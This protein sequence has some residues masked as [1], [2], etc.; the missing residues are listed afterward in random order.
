MPQRP[1][2]PSTMNAVYLTGHGG[3]EV[4]EYVDTAPVPTPDAGEVLIEVTAC[5]MNNTDIWV[6]E[7]AYGTDDDPN[8]TASWRRG[9]SDNSLQFPRI[10]GG[11]TVGVIVDTG[12]SVDPAR[13][14]ERVMIDFSIYNGDGISLSDIDY[15]GPR[16]RWWLCRIY[17]CSF[18]SS[19]PQPHRHERR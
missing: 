3:P 18:R 1:D 2:I 17:G 5:G 6:R 9:S 16:T 11:D 4:L 19:P 14:G 7:G 10:Q 8:A 13:I 12:T 15:F